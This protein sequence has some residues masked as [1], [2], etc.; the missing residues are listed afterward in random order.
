MTVDRERSP[1][2][3][4]LTERFREL[5]ALDEARAPEF[6]QTWAG[7]A[8]RRPAPSWRW[9]ALGVGATALVA[10][11]VAVL[12]VLLSPG[13]SPA[14]VA[15]VRPT[16]ALAFLLEPPLSVAPRTVEFDDDPYDLRLAEVLENI[17]RGV[18][19]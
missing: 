11:P 3:R 18:E 14:P 5:R 16:E 6:V 4:A 17:D 2:E 1:E 9:A 10:G 13:E 12:L 7:A 8:R 15:A 19:R